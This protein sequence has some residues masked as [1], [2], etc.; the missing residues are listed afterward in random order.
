MYVEAM[1][2]KISIEKKSFSDVVSHKGKKK[3][4]QYHKLSIYLGVFSKYMYIVRLMEY[5]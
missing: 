2:S 4:T 1:K 3:N 5:T